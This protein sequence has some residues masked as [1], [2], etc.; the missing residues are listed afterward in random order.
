MNI[1]E[2]T[3]KIVAFRE[4]RDWKQFHN[5]KD[6][7]ASLV[8][9]ASEVLEI[10]QWINGEDINKQVAKKKEELSDELA[11]VL[12]WVLLMSHDTQIDI[13]KALD[14]KIRKNE[15]KYPVEKAKGSAKKYTEL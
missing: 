2:L 11:D 13:L 14:E 5:P 3:K 6:I 7:A 9:E 12:Y 4:A 8:L 10:F 15:I 1:E